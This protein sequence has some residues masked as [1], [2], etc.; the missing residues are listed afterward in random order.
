M[1][2]IKIGKDWNGRG[3]I[4]IEDYNDTHEYLI[5]TEYKIEEISIFWEC[6]DEM[7]VFNLVVRCKNDDREIDININSLTTLN[8]NNF[9]YN[10]SHIDIEK[11]GYTK[12]IKKLVYSGKGNVFWRVEYAL[13]KFMD[14]QS[15]S[16]LRDRYKRYRYISNMLSSDF[17]QENTEKESRME[18]LRNARRAKRRKTI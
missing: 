5:D 11:Y 15:R 3:L 16:S 2:L 10:A 12:G 17:D 18:E 1:R 13:I 9:D 8:V 7:D 14:S 4:V 6:G